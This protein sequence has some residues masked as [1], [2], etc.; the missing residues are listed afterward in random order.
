MKQPGPH[1]EDKLLDFTYGELAAAEAQDV[2][3]HLQGCPT[4]REA[5]ES[6]EGVRRVM[7]RLPVEAAP[8]TGLESILGYAEQAAR[9][10]K[11]G[12]A[13]KPTWWRRWLVPVAGLAATLVVVVGV[14]TRSV[15]DAPLAL[16]EL[17]PAPVAAPAAEQKMG[18]A[19]SAPA[20]ESEQQNIPGNRL[21]AAPE[22]AVVAKAEPVPVLREPALDSIEKDV[23]AFKGG[24]KMA[25]RDA[26]PKVAFHRAA[27]AD[28]KDA[29][30]QEDLSR[31]AALPA[32][33]PSFKSLAKKEVSGEAEM[34]DGIA[35]AKV[36][37]SHGAVA[38]DESVAGPA[39]RKA[40][41]GLAAAGQMGGGSSSGSLA[42]APPPAPNAPSATRYRSLKQESE[43]PAAPPATV[44]SA[45]PQSESPYMER[46]AVARE[47]SKKQSEDHVS[48]LTRQALDAERRGNYGAANAYLQEAVAE[49]TGDRRV[50]LL[51][52]WCRVAGELNPDAVPDPEP[53][54][55]LQA[56]RPGS[57]SLQMLANRRAKRAAPTLDMESPA[58]ADKAKA[59]PA[60][61]APASQQSAQ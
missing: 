55:Q 47:E 41:A 39:A 40:P 61:S 17:K 42:A 54:R 43:P 21:S 2:E 53:C 49:A 13:P 19:A 9:R 57:T 16:S 24:D 45:Q 5:L 29:E 32:E 6:I 20:E 50:A 51:D 28:R 18:E 59:R 30:A 23:G 37:P 7:A 48:V 25:K 33:K 46:G 1:I 44:A 15:K 3:A 60:Q 4:C 31:H 52:D 27:A 26:A 56:Q 36:V 35:P 34:D 11:A 38:S 8:D 14:A 22:A 58:K 12:P 10:S